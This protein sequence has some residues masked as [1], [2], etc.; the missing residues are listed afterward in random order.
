MQCGVSLWAKSFTHTYFGP[1]CPHSL[2]LAFSVS[3]LLLL[4]F[5]SYSLAFIFPG[6]SWCYSGLRLFVYNFLGGYFAVCVC[7]YLLPVTWQILI[8]YANYIG[9]Y[10]IYF[11]LHSQVSQPSA[12]RKTILFCFISF[13]ARADIEVVH[14]K[15]YTQ[16]SMRCIQVSA[17]ILF[18]IMHNAGN[19]CFGHPGFV[20][21]TC[22][23]EL[24]HIYKLINVCNT[25]AIFV[26]V[27]L[28][29]CVSLSLVLLK[30]GL[31][32]L[33]ILL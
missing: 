27:C 24:L 20:L 9:K 1:V 14:A 28:C 7:P 3:S 6:L 5:S 17:F 18:K 2:S 15:T 30:I 25:L 10:S 22:E 23:C 13:G 12:G 4:F 32:Q 21:F 16:W 11:I 19:S 33:E 29:V 8:V 26:Y 31:N